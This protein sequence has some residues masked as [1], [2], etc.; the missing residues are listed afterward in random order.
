M[1]RIVPISLLFLTA[2]G[3]RNAGTGRAGSGSLSVEWTGSSRGRFSAPATARWCA[4]DSLLEVLAVRN[5]TAF[6]VALMAQDSVRAGAYPV[7][8][9]RPFTPGRPQASAALR[10]LTDVA[11]KGYEAFGG[12]VTVTEGG[13]RLVSGTIEVRL[14]VPAGADTL[15]LTGSFQRIPIGPATGSCGRADKPRAR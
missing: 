15:H 10:W 11:L 12:A 7:H 3:P 4:M 5:D 9:I 14:R 2:C 13:G 6:G 1:R 8:E